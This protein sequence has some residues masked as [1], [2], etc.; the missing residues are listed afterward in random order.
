MKKFLL[1][2]SIALLVVSCTD[3]RA[4]D[5]AP[6]TC[7]LSASPTIKSLTYDNTGRVATLTIESYYDTTAVLVL[8]TFSYDAASKLAKTVYTVNGKPNSEETYT[9]TDGRIT[10]VNFSGPNSPTGINNLSYDA[11]GHLTRYTVEVGG[12]VQFAQTYAYNADGVITEQAAVSSQGDVLYRAVTKPVGSVKS[13]EQ[14]LVKHG[15]PYLVATGT[16][17]SV[18]EGGVGTVT[19]YYSTDSSGKLVLAG[20]QNVSS[21]KTNA[22]GYLTEYT[23]TDGDGKNPTTRTY[24]LTDCQ[25]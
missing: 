25:N 17:L 24:T 19:E 12:Q 3:H 8:S 9:Y 16:P 18:A 22:Q 15:V 10:R 4:N 14:L 13:P 2:C 23:L 11:S 1:F 6:D 21:V 5:P 20:S 7:K